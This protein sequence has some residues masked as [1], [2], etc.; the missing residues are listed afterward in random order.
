MEAS[1]ISREIDVAN[2]TL[3][4]KHNLEFPSHHEVHFL[5]LVILVTSGVNTA[6][7]V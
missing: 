4:E 2:Q 5:L 7:S 6:R 3:E 1:I